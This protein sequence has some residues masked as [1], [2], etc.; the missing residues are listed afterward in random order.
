MTTK[1]NIGNLN[2]LTLTTKGFIPIGDNMTLQSCMNTAIGNGASDGKNKFVAINP[3]SPPDGTGILMRG[4]CLLGGDSNYNPITD[5]DS[6]EFNTNN[7]L[8][9]IYAVPN[10]ACNNNDDCLVN[11]AN[12]FLANEKISIQALIDSNQKELTDASIRLFAIENELTFA[13]ATTEYNLIEQKKKITAQTKILNMKKSLL[14]SHLAELTNANTNSKILLSDKNKLL[15][16]VNSNIQQKYTKLEKV[17]NDINTVT[18]DIYVNNADSE[19]KENIIKTLKTIIII[20]TIMAAIMI[21]Y[22]GMQ[23][24]EKNYPDVYNTFNNGLNKIGFQGYG[25]NIFI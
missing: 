19:R 24:T 16:T 4:S 3:L 10:S 5:P 25:N 12:T 9:E 13:A 21:V 20:V 2:K 22:I 14:Q 1:Y 23:F 11:N 15:A 6:T 18:Q 8:Y 7:P 17:N